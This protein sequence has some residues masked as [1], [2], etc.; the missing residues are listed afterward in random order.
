MRNMLRYW[1]QKAQGIIEYAALLSMGV[2]SVYALWV[3]G[4]IP[5]LRLDL[6]QIFSSIKELI[7]KAAIG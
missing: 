2:L 5:Y 6:L 1:S 3:V 7:K 4:V